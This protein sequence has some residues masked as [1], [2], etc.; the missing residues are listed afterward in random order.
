MLERVIG[1]PKTIFVAYIARCNFL[2]L[3]QPVMSSCQKQR[4]CSNNSGDPF[5]MRRCAFLCCT[6]NGD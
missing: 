1:A 4:L 5:E 2:A 3:Q 6:D